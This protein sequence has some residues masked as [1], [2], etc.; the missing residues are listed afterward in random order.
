LAL[1]VF[2]AGAFAA[3]A[4]M[5][6][7]QMSLEQLRTLAE[8]LTRPGAEVA[9]A[10]RL[11]FADAIRALWIVFAAAPLGFAWSAVSRGG[12]PGKALLHLTVRD[13]S[14]GAP[15]GFGRALAREAVRLLHVALVF[16]TDPRVGVAGMLAWLAMTLDLARQKASRT[17]YD[18]LTRS[19]VV[20]PAELVEPPDDPR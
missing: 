12:S 7:S 14:S 1:D 6:A 18:R 8:E 15:L 17:W 19:I 13:F 11:K 16:A 5:A 10:E 2:L 9:E 4:A 20:V 3:T